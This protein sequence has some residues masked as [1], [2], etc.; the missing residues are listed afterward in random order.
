MEL[1]RHSRASPR[2]PTRLA[3][4][5]ARRICVSGN[6]SKL[7]CASIALLYPV[8]GARAPKE[9]SQYKSIR[10]NTSQ[11]SWG[12]NKTN[13]KN[14]SVGLGGHYAHPPQPHP[15]ASPASRRAPAPPVKPLYMVDMICHYLLVIMFLCDSLLPSFASPQQPYTCC[16][17]MCIHTRTVYTHCRHIHCVEMV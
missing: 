12:G 8:G 11:Y 4:H 10:V 7:G 13:S 1:L 3:V 6:A 17:H 5:C 15:H 14:Q 9:T 16:I 2:V